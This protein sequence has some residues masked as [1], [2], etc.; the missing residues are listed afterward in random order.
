MNGRLFKIFLPIFL[1]LALL[2]TGLVAVVDIASNSLVSALGALAIIG[3]LWQS[4]RSLLNLGSK[5]P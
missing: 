1:G 3:G 5:K 2:V 4:Q